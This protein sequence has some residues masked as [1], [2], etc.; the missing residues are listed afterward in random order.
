MALGTLIHIF[1]L[2]FSV[3]FLS[4]FDTVYGLLTYTKVKKIISKGN[5]ICGKNDK[6]MTMLWIACLDQY[7]S[8]VCP[9]VKAL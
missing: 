6:L 4:Q 3:V 2:F 8:K 9:N 1:I 5:S 7:E